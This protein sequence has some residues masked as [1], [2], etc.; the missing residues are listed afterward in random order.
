MFA[1]DTVILVVMTRRFVAKRKLLTGNWQQ[2]GSSNLR[3]FYD[4]D[5]EE[6]SAT[7]SRQVDWSTPLSLPVNYSALHTQFFELSKTFVVCKI[8]AH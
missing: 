6:E 1:A 5:F 8:I 2:L 4:E 3:D 7:L